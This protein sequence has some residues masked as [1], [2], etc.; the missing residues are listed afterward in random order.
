MLSR[1]FGIVPVI[2]SYLRIGEGP[3]RSC[4]P[5]GSPLGLRSLVGSSRVREYS[6]RRDSHGHG[7]PSLGAPCEPTR[8]L[9]PTLASVHTPTANRVA[10]ESETSVSL[11]PRVC[12]HRPFYPCLHGNS[13][14]VFTD[15]GR[16]LSRGR[17]RPQ[18]V[19]RRKPTALFVDLRRDPHGATVASDSRSREPRSR[20][21]ASPRSRSVH[22]PTT[23]APSRTVRR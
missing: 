14:G 17:R 19:P 10:D 13:I 5:N 22:G 15:R 2:R 6:P 20:Y 7:R 21:T 4:H 16:E 3:Y 18:R 9:S 11:S 8:S 1:R 12:V 23:P